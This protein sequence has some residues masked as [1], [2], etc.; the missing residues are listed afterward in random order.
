MRNCPEKNSLKP[1]ALGIAWAL[2]A[3][4][5]PLFAQSNEPSKLTPTQRHMASGPLQSARLTLTL[6]DA[7]ARAQK[8]DAQFLATVTDAKVAH[9]DTA[10]AG[11]AILPSLGVRSE[12]LGTQG[13]GRLAS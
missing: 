5:L 7:L 12:Y 4:L 6:H 8:N 1:R 2:V 9:E 3:S 10:Q 13:N 11:A